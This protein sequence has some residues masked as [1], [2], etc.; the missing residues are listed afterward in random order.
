MDEQLHEIN[1]RA[2]GD[3]ISNSSNKE[4]RISGEIAAK[5][6]MGVIDVTC[7]E[8]LVENQRVCRI[9]HLNGKE[10]GE[11]SVE[12]IE[13]GCGCK[14]ELGVAHLCC[15]EAWFRVRGYRMCEICSETAKNITGVGDIRFME[16]W[17]ES[18]SPT[19]GSRRWLSGQLLCSFLMAFLVIAFVL[20]WF[21]RV[22]I[23]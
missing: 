2:G 11:N 7:D 21:F 20:P 18:Q 14:G 17:R 5:S 15:A 22:N 12:L 3:D 6:K 23:L 13:L 8:F 9:C 19:G 4:S 16:E 1:Q 10:S